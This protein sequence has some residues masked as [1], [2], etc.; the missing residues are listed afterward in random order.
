MIQ[1]PA[2]R[3]DKLDCGYL[4]PSGGVCHVRWMITRD[5]P[6]V[7]QVEQDSYDYPWREE[8][9]LRCLRQRNCIGMVAEIGK[10]VAGFMIYELDKLKIHIRNFAVHPEHRRNAIGSVMMD[11]LIAKLSSPRRASIAIE[12][13]ETNLA[14]QLFLRD[15]GFKAQRVMREHFED[16]GEDAYLMCYSIAWP[17]LD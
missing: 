15:S 5:M 12:V 14:G 11:K 6:E 17:K 4:L 16:S 1:A 10:Q 3:F 8:D 9:F 7:I 2:K 13:R